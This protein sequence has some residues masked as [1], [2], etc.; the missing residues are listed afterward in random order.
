MSGRALFFAGS[1]DEGDSTP[2]GQGSQDADAVALSGPPREQRLFLADSD[3]EQEEERVF[4]FDGPPGPSGPAL[5]DGGDDFVSEAE[6]LPF[7]EV[8][9]ASSV[10]SFSSG[11]SA[12]GSSPAPSESSL[13]P[14]KKRRLLPDTASAPPSNTGDSYLGCL[15]I[16]NAWSTSKGKG[17]V[18]PGDEIL[19]ERDDPDDAPRFSKSKN[20]EGADKGKKRQLTLKAMMN[21]QPSKFVKRK[22]DI[23][24]RLT[25]KAGFGEWLLHG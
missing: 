19:V 13:P 25:N 22:A 2:A 3:E 18:S 6:L 12:K 21:P 11:L 7:E 5:P 16:G 17:Y 1:D 23:V 4:R 8:P 10:S 24:I 9:R 20:K 14:A 15:V